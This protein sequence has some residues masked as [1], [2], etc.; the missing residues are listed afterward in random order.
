MNRYPCAS[1]QSSYTEQERRNRDVVVAFYENGVNRHD[2]SAALSCLGENYIQHSP[3]VA[4]GV[5]GF[6]D[7]FT[8]L[9]KEHPRFRIEVKRIFLEGDMAA[10]HVRT[11]GGAVPNGE[12]RVDIFRFENGR[13]VEHWDV[14]RPIPAGAANSNSMF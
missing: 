8:E 4:D 14:A 1:D 6:V 12:A 2:F 9:W 13:I 5:Q 10:V 11:H 7:F 3:G